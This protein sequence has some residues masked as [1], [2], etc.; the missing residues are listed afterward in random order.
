MYRH[1]VQTCA[2]QQPICLGYLHCCRSI[3]GD[4]FRQRNG[5]EHPRR[6][7]LPY[8]LR[9]KFHPGNNG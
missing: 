8:E 9:G 3:D 5:D 7:K 4:S 6:S 1:L 2:L